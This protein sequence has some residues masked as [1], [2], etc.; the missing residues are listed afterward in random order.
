MVMAGCTQQI[1]TMPLPLPLA[2]ELELWAG[3]VVL[4]RLQR[5]CVWRKRHPHA[6][7][8]SGAPPFGLSASCGFPL[9][10]VEEKQGFLRYQ[11]IVSVLDL[12]PKAS[13]YRGGYSR[14]AP[15]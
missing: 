8:C 13:L 6:A 12:Y 1:L 9:G 15:Y 14:F 3:A 11:V 2:T 4:Q 5:K 10:S 7:G